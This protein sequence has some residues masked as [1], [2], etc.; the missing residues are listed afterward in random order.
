MLMVK[1]VKSE[2]GYF[3]CCLLENNQ[4]AISS[5][6]TASLHYLNLRK[7]N[8]NAAKMNAPY[9]FIFAAFLKRR[10]F[11]DPQGHLLPS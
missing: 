1:S 2:F 9:A 6:K 11:P 7:R 8:K 5:G 3:E 4:V 10:S